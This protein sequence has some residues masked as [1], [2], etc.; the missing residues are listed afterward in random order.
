M[1][2]CVRP[3]VSRGEGRVASR[4]CLPNNL[5]SMSFLHRP[6]LIPSLAGS[7]VYVTVPTAGTTNSST[8]EW[9]IKNMLHFV[10]VMVFESHVELAELELEV[11]EWLLHERQHDC[12]QDGQQTTGRGRGWV[13][14][15]ESREGGG[16]WALSSSS[17]TTPVSSQAS[18]SEHG[19][20]RHARCTHTVC[21]VQD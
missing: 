2:A 17:F 19:E 4:T 20:S 16:G 15:Q 18:F 8:A 3:V 9:S 5:N 7:M 13:G 1:C 10:V 11:D 12:T 14:M 6:R 21:Q